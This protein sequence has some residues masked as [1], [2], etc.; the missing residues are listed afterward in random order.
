[1]RMGNISQAFETNSCWF[2]RDLYTVSIIK[3]A[4]FRLVEEI[5]KNQTPLKSDQYW[6]QVFPTH[7][8]KR[9]WTGVSLSIGLHYQMYIS[10]WNTAPKRKRRE[11]GWL[12]CVLNIPC[13]GRDAWVDKV[14]VQGQFR[15]VN[16]KKYAV[17]CYLSVSHL[18]F[19][20]LALLVRQ[21]IHTD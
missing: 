5:C 8:D 14:Q 7:I 2:N 1:M 13:T 20:D 17:L 9:A 4:Q 16:L 6:L 18:R 19:S 15:S 10:R 12:G 11:V 3:L 21:Q